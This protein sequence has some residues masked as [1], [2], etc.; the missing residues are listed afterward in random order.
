MQQRITATSTSLADS[1]DSSFIPTQLLT[2]RNSE[3]IVAPRRFLEKLA[4]ET[5]GLTFFSLKELADGITD[6]FIDS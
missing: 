5:G 3:Y 6:V 2:V 4:E 1:R